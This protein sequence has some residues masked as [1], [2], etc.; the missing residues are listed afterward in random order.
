MLKKPLLYFNTIRYLKFSQIWNRVMRNLFSPT[1]DLSDAPQVQRNSVSFIQVI[2]YEQKMFGQNFFKF[3]NKEF[4]L[5]NSHS[6]NSSD[7]EKLLLYNLHYFDD[8]NAHNSLERIEWH[9]ELIQ[10]WINENPPNYGNGWE[11]YPTSLRMVNWIKWSLMNGEL[12]IDALNSLAKQARHLYQNLE[13]HLLGNHLFKN[14]KAL[15]F[16]GLFFK[17]EEADNWFNKGVA[18]FDKELSEQILDD[19]GNFELSPMYHS[20]FLEDLLDLI[21]IYKS[22][23]KVLPAHIIS[24]SIQMLDWL[25]VMLHPDRDIAFFNDSTLKIAPTYD[26]L[27]SY[28]RRLDVPYMGKKTPQFKHLKESGYIV[29]N[30]ENQFIVADIASI[31]PDYIP[32]HGHA[33]TLSFEMS[34][35]GNRIIVNSG[36][37]TYKLDDIRLKQRG[38]LAHSTIT[39]DDK[40]S[41]EV[42]SGFRVASRAKIFNIKKNV[43]TDSI[44][45]SAC[46]DGYKKLKGRVVHCREWLVSNYS[47]EVIDRIDGIGEHVVR[48]VLPLHPNVKITSIQE[49]KV[50]LR[51]DSTKFEIIFKGDG[52]LK[53]KADQYNQGFGLSFANQHLIYEYNGSLPYKCKIIISW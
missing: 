46:H 31:G 22:Y 36:I 43:T 3:L 2:E 20:I 17:G 12:T 11:P 19:G 49:N 32:G 41:S 5:C 51:V 26:D 34:L 18:I 25:K 53:V 4:N 47:L 27:M 40:N 15:I 52:I 39:I 38:S 1:I 29:V 14:A 6:W 45:F 42:W 44:N 8:L 23:N 16:V 10:K 50:Y 30:K 9:V 7:E 24:K 21:N 48:S 13:Y 33:D 35:S 28:S 37:S